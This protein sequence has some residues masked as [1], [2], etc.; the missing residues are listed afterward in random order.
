[1]VYRNA[2]KKD[3]EG[4]AVLHA[5]SWQ[6][7]YRGALSDDFLDNRALSDR[8]TVWRERLQN[9]DSEKQVIV[10]ELD[11]KIEGF[12]CFFFEHNL[13]FGT[14]LDNLH[15]SLKLKGQGIGTKLMRIAAKAIDKMHPDSS[16]Y[17]WVLE[18]NLDAIRFYEALGGKKLET[19]EEID[20][21]DLPVVKSRYYWKSVRSLIKD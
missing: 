1:M 20:I 8:M 13:S 16:M 6:E 12:V 9:S 11:G 7:N 15:V 3:I 10:A 2:T 4:I 18:Q 19:V 14:L 5:K 17:L 21:G